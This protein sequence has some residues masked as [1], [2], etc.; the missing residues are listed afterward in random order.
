M[1]KQYWQQNIQLL[2]S[3]QS[4]RKY[5]NDVINSHSFIN[6]VNSVNSA[7]SVNSVNSVNSANLHIKIFEILLNG[8][9]I[10][11]TFWYDGIV[12]SNEENSLIKPEIL[13]II[14]EFLFNNYD[15]ELWK[16]VSNNN[17]IFNLY[18]NLKLKYENQMQRREEMIQLSDEYNVN[19]LMRNMQSQELNPSLDSLLSGLNLSNLGNT[20]R[21]KSIYKNRP[22]NA[23]IVKTKKKSSIYKKK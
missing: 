10:N 16:Q 1:K 19:E 18:N 8:I 6:S 2:Y 11:S 13:Y 23:V 20:D 15:F 21:N 5:Y 17:I 7:N 4:V 3:L 14:L 12:N 9:I 22:K